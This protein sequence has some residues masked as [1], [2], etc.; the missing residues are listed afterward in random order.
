MVEMIA[1]S[2]YSFR[3]KFERLGERAVMIREL[4]SEA[5]RWAKA[6][7]ASKSLPG[8]LEAVASYDT[9]GLYFEG[10]PDLLESE[11]W[12]TD[13][14]IADYESAQLHIIPVC[15]ELG[16][17]LESCANELGIST[18]ALI[19]AH[20]APEYRCFAVGFVPGFAYL[21]Y[22]PDS[23][24]KLPRRSSPRSRVEPGSVAV[25]GRQTA[26]YPST[27]PGGWNLIGRCPLKLVDE[28]EGYFPIE[29]GDRVSFR[30]IDHSEFARLNG[31]RL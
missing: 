17:D 24:G 9:L 20:L 15:Y 10:E 25:T 12:L 30:R 1:E 31:E 7:N 27:S 19:D 13:L 4:P 5:Y 26:V 18:D 11:R 29:A 3:M 6:A 22:L 2:A 21:G 14:P 8:F 16:E 23:I 28:T